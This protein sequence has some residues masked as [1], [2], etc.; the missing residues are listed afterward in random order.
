MKIKSMK[1]I[2]T[3]SALLV[4]F[5]A[6]LP[7][8]EANAQFGSSYVLPPSAPSNTQILPCSY[9]DGSQCGFGQE[10]DSEGSPTP[11]RKRKAYPRS[12]THITRKQIRQLINKSGDSNR[13]MLQF[14]V[15]E[16]TGSSKVRINGHRLTADELAIFSEELGCSQL[17]AN[18]QN[19]NIQN[20]M[21]KAIKSIEDATEDCRRTKKC[22]QK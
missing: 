15:C 18:N 1:K 16:N 3:V 14:A 20:P 2:K 10:G 7:F 12:T 6:L 4:T 19:T 17:N 11:I 9:G 22:Y 13:G 8:K 5:I 21:Q